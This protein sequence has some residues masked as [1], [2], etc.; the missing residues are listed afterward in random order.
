MERGKNQVSAF[1]S[2][3]R[4]AVVDVCGGIVM[5][6][7]KVTGAQPLSRSL[8]VRHSDAASEQG[9]ASAAGLT[10]V[11]EDFFEGLDQQKLKSK[12]RDYKQFYNTDVPPKSVG[13]KSK[14]GVLHHT[15]QLVSRTSNSIGSLEKGCRLEGRFLV[16]SSW[17][18]RLRRALSALGLHS[19]ANLVDLG[20]DEVK[21]GVEFEARICNDKGKLVGTRRSAADGDGLYHLDVEFTEEEKK[22]I[23]SDRDLMFQILFRGIRNEKDEHGHFNSFKD[24]PIP[25]GAG[26]IRL[27]E[28]GRVVTSSDVDKT[29]LDTTVGPAYFYQEPWSRKFMPGAAQLFAA[30]D[31]TLHTISGSEQNVSTGI[32]AAFELHGV[33]PAEADFKDWSHREK[34]EGLR[35]GGK[36]LT[37]QIGFKLTRELETDQHLPEGVRMKAHGDCT[38]Y[39]PIV[40]LLLHGILCGDLDA[41]TI[42]SIASNRAEWPEL[43][44]VPASDLQKIE[45]LSTLIGKRQGY[46]LINI[47]IGSTDPEKPELKNL[48]GYSISDFVRFADRLENL[49]PGPSFYRDRIIFT[50]NYLQTALYYRQTGDNRVTDDVVLAVGKDLVDHGFTPDQIA[51]TLRK[52]L[53]K[54]GVQTPRRFLRKDTIAAIAP[55][56]V[57]AGVLPE[58][59]KV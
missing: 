10:S 41:G 5:D 58:N 43:A 35:M 33:E 17:D 2:L 36:R 34:G 47:N 1:G 29:M 27:V 16:F 31:D 57:D 19:V 50:D 30:L 53:E 39:D 46:E 48:H 45:S 7:G 40:Y 4:E 26:K 22:S 23:G 20:T 3:S 44:K 14:K 21:G 8:E 11:G 9:E 56:L 6:A 25:V 51:G 32:L 18:H 15:K 28:G 59:F 24:S 38:E 37:E 42:R 13:V 12:W 52:V 54:G 55:R 49:H